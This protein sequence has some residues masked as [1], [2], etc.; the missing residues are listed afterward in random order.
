MGLLDMMR[1]Q[2]VPT[3]QAQAG[4]IP[5][6]ADPGKRP[7]GNGMLG[8]RGAGGGKGGGPPP[9][10]QMDAGPA[11]PPQPAQLMPQ[12]APIAAVVPAMGAVPMGGG[13]GGPGGPP[14]GG[15]PGGPPMGGNPLM[16]QA[17]MQRLQQQR[18]GGM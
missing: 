15:P 6:N 18:G 16:M 9:V 7:L 4:G 14:M 10:Q 13:A 1:G 3:A 5:Q 17:L 8:L 2:Q 11:A 12:Q